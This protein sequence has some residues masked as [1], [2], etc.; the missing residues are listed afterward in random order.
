[1]ES[2][3]L[4]QIKPHFHVEIIEPKQVYLLGEQGNHALT[5]QL[6]C[7]ILPLLNGQYTIEQIVQ[8]LD[9]EVPPDYIDYVLNRLAEKGYLTEAAPELSPEVAAFW[10]ELGIAPPVAAQGLQQSVTLTTVGQGISE[11]TVVL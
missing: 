5:G 11:V 9:G 2:T 8:K 6:Y 3:T 10:S 4:P 7:Q 1:M